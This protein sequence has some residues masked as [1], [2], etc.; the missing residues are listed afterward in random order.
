MRQCR[1]FEARIE[2]ETPGTGWIATLLY[3]AG[4]ALYLAAALAAFVTGTLHMVDGG[5]ST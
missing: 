2:L 3:P 1:D 5:M 4:T